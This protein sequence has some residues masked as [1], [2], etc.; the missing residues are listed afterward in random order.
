YGASGVQ[1]GPTTSLQTVSAVTRTINTATPGNPTGADSP[2]LLANLLGNPNLKPETSAELEVG[3]ESRLFENRG[4]IDF[5][6]YHKKTKDALISQPIAGSAAP[7]SLSITRNL[8]SVMN[9][10]V[11][12]QVTMQLLD[13]R[14]FGWD[15]TLNGSHNTNKILSLGKDATGAPNPTIGTGTTRDSVGLPANAWFFVPYTFADANGDG[16][17]SDSEVQVGSSA[18][19]M[20]YSQPRDIFSI[21]NGFDLLRRK[22][23]LSFLLDYKGGNSLFNNTGQF[24]CANQPTCYE[25]TNTSASLA[26]QARVIAERYTPVTTT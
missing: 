9:S 15:V 20:G 10:G 21:Q 16:L 1:P 18:V 5:T 24:Y 17:I 22:L 4:S 25:E 7:S 14:A 23:R 26:R 6:Y 11:E 12:A 19:Y 13:R 2:S 3:F 8:G